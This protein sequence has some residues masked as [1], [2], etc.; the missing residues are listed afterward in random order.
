MSQPISVHIEVWSDYVCP[1]CYLQEP[2]FRRLAKEHGDAIEVHWRAFELRPAPVPTLEPDCGYL[3][4]IWARAVYPMAAEREMTLRLPPVQPRSRKAL[5][6][7]EVAREQGL[8]DRMHSALF[9]AFFEHGLDIGETGVLVD[10]GRNAGLDGEALRRALDAGSYTA[11]VSSDAEEAK[12]LGIT[13]VPLMVI[14]PAGAGEDAGVG[15]SGAHSYETV[16]ASI[17]RVRSDFSAPKY[18]E[19][20]DLDDSGHRIRP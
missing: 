15:I 10:I 6:A 7:A 3:Q 2:V 18:S 19:D 16:V 8:F 1:F 4:S 5:E 17:A 14:R 11:R 13:G 20:T 12:C 9:K